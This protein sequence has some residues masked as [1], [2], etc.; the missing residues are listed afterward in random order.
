MAVRY[1]TYDVANWLAHVNL[2][3]ATEI[4]FDLHALRP[5]KGWDVA[6]TMRRFENYIWPMPG[7]YNLPARLGSDGDAKIGSTQVY[8]LQVDLERLGV[9]LP[10]MRSPAP[11]LAVDYTVTI[12]ETQH[13][14]F[15]NS[16]RALWYRFAG[17]IGAHVIEDTSRTPITLYERVALYAG[18]KMNFG[19]PNG[20][21]ALMYYTSYPFRIMADPIVNA[22]SFGGHR[23]RVGETV[24]W[25]LPDQR[26]I[27]ERATMD[28]LMREVEQLEE[29]A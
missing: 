7:L 6:E 5:G 8:D 23:I 26:I 11:L 17:E 12:R 20:P 10:R 25:L 18:A 28:N 13:N 21:M 16:D 22:K 27:W 14:P 15:K 4:V 2:L 1:S 3:G 29:V 24:P 19:V 9:E